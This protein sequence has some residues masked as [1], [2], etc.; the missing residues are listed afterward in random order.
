M[1]SCKCYDL[2]VS[3]GLKEVLVL[4]IPYKVLDPA[5]A[6]STINICFASAAG[7]YKKI[8]VCFACLLPTTKMNETK[9]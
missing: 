1:F 3:A 7:N 9:A 6:K 5:A 4:C 8:D 2:R